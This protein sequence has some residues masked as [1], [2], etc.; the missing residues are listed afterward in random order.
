M[1]DHVQH[2]VRAQ[3]RDTVR[4]RLQRRQRRSRRQSVCAE[5][6][7]QQNVRFQR[8]HL[9]LLRFVLVG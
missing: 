4:T 7:R 9:R 3:H 5:T 1:E 8:Q 6:N 2:G